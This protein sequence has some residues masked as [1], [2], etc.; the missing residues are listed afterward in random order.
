MTTT[1]ERLPPPEDPAAFESLCL[2]LWRD[3]LSDP[4]AKKNG[5]RGQPQAGVD[6]F[7]QKDGKWTGIQCKQKDGLLRAKVTWRELGEEAAKAKLFQPRLSTFI[8]TTNG[9]R[10]PEVQLPAQQLSEYLKGK[11]LFE[12]QVWSWE[13]M[14]HELFPREELMKRIMP[15]YWP[16]IDPTVIAHP[17]A[18]ER[19]REI[20][21]E[22]RF[23]SDI[24]LWYS[25]H[26]KEE[27]INLYRLLAHS[28]LRCF[29][30]SHQVKCNLFY[31]DELREALLGSR[32]VCF[33]CS[34]QML[35]SEAA[36]T[37]WGAAWALRKRI[38]LV[39]IRMDTRDLPRR[40]QAT[41]AISFYEKEVFAMEVLR[42]GQTHITAFERRGGT[43]NGVSDE[44]VRNE[45]RRDQQEKENWQ[46][47]LDQRKE[48]ELRGAVPL[49]TIDH[50]HF[51]V[52][53]PR[54]LRPGL[55]HPLDVWSHL[56]AQQADVLRRAKDQAATPDIRIKSQGPVKLVRGTEMTV[57]LRIPRLAVTPVENFLLWDGEIANAGFIVTVPLEMKATTCEGE[58]TIHVG[59]LTI[60]RLA[61]VL[62][63][64]EKDAATQQLDL[65][66][67][68]YS[69]AFA[70]YAHEDA[71]AVLGRIQGIQKV[72]PS[73]DIFFDVAKLRSGE[74]WQE[75]LKHEILSRE[76]LYLFWSKAA[77]QSKWVDWE[78]HCGY[79]E[80]GIDFID[81]VPLVSPTDVPPPKELTELHFN[82]W[83]LAYMRSQP[84][85][86]K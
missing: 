57:R 34:P 15:I 43:R 48:R 73:L 47:E 49:S 4:S 63:I 75:R 36:L 50:V 31:E 20:M 56:A 23:I 11:G 3:M 17:A 83:V 52:T 35:K 41:R 59:G 81:P 24:F 58:A 42:R 33:L 72:A 53:A 32:E 51:T 71:D 65:K 5:R 6:V 68:R 62:E 39:L 37:L 46:R 9:V 1:F 16:W 19:N 18:S 78:W 80:H 70:S 29:L 27:A 45:E 14:W 54:T 79:Q 77:S 21:N 61:F 64:A 76:V 38:T 13:D 74:R 8:L 28:G 30:P 69:K 86:N 26:D 66:V 25:D 55:A 84:E 82:D 7:G 40:L 12:I 2:D 85:A 60:V 44:N 10:D 67:R 22:A